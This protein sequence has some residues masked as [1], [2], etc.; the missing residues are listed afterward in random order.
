MKELIIRNETEDDYTTVERLTRDAFW[1]L[2]VPGCDEHYLVHIMREHID[3]IPELALV[4]ELDGQ[5]VGNIMYTKAKLIDEGKKEKNILTFGPLSVHPD[6]QRQGIGKKL[7]EHSFAKAM[8]M[9]YDAVVIFGIPGNYV[10]RG[11][12]S[13]KKYNICSENNT[14]PTAMLVKELSPNIFDGRK[15]Y[16]HDTP[17]YDVDQAK[18]QEFD[19]LFEAKQKEY[20]A[21]QEEFYIH[22]HSVIQ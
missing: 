19:H 17:L 10:S 8:A 18:A 13:C 12:K 20:Q 16:Y 6:F 11:F 22:S 3:F 1:N 4:A 14:F 21:S 15:W 7:I 2:Y 9:E 5:I